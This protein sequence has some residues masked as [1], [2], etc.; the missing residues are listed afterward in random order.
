VRARR[1]PVIIAVA[2]IAIAGPAYAK[3]P[4]RSS[5]PTTYDVSYPQCGSSLPSTASGGIVG[6]NDGIVLSANPCFGTEWAWATK[7]PSYAP[8]IYAN[9]GD[10]G[11]ARSSHW[12]TGATTPKAC[13][14]TNSV[15]CSYD[16]GWRAA[17]DSFAD[18]GKA[19]P[20]PIGYPWW[21]DVETGNSWQT[22]ESDYGQTASS[23]A[24]DIAALQGEVD[25]LTANGVSTVG[26]YSTSYQWQQITGG[27]GGTFAGSPAWLAGSS[28]LTNAQAACQSTSFTGGKV[29]LTQ[30]RSSGYDADY[31]CA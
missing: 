25:A 27:T 5:S 28:A 15:D 18:A 9:T 7:A 8:A 19:V 1:L 30:Y 2:S 11:P 29:T 4:S 14:G 6:V 10:P 23:R 22:L 21:L 24:N 12:P 17:Q 31:H 13:D 20:A 26:F 16:Y 3:T